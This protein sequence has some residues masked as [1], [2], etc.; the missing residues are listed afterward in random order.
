MKIKPNKFFKRKQFKRNVVYEFST[1]I[2]ICYIVLGRDEMRH[3]KTTIC[4]LIK[5]HYEFR[6]QSQGLVQLKFVWF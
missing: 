1:P 6:L 4:P 5:R 2:F 3:Q